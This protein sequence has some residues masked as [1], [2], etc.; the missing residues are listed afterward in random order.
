MSKTF[1]LVGEKGAGKDSLALN[2][3][4]LTKTL[5]G[6]IINL[7]FAEPIHTISAAVF[8]DVPYNERDLKKIISV[9]PN[10]ALDIALRAYIPNTRT[11]HQVLNRAVEVFSEHPEIDNLG[12]ESFEL[13]WRL[14][15]QLIGTEIIREAVDQDFFIK[16]LKDTRESLLLSTFGK[17]GFVIT[18]ARF[19]NEFKVADG[20]IGIVRSGAERKLV[21]PNIHK[22]ERWGQRITVA[23]TDYRNGDHSAYQFLNELFLEECGV[24]LLGIMESNLDADGEVYFTQL[25][26]GDYGQLTSQNIK[27]TRQV[28]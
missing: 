7:K 27:A 8:G 14:F 20:I 1:A 4:A 6:S 9:Q 18:D 22:S 13:S 25:V 26:R 5:D 28:C 16:A 2:M 12:N 3:Q 24:P 19:P 10:S 15:A 11:I 23:A 21:D 17:M